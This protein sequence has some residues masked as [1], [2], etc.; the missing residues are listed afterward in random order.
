MPNWNIVHGEGSEHERAFLTYLR[1]LG[2]DLPDPER[3]YEFASERR[4]RFDFAWPERMVAVEIDGGTRMVGGGRHG[5][6]GDREKL[7]L[8]ASKGWRVLRF[9]GDMLATDPAG[10]FDILRITLG[11]AR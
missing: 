2:K 3:E 8:A 6:D 5:G 11:D 7:N 10:C 9:S 1:V 4:Y